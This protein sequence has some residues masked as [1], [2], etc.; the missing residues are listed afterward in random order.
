MKGEG[1]DPLLSWKRLVP[2]TYAKK[3]KAVALLN[4][5]PGLFGDTLAWMETRRQKPDA[6][7]PFFYGEARFG[8]YINI[9][10]ECARARVM[11]TEYKE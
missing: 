6:P 5:H 4:G 9:I 8:R 7:N 3:Q 10:D 11:T 1:P 2:A